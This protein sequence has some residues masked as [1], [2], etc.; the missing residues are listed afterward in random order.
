[1]YIVVISAL[2]NS[3]P[4]K[5]NAGFLQRLITPL[6]SANTYKGFSQAVSLKECGN[7]VVSIMPFKY[8]LLLSTTEIII[9]ISECALSQ[10]LLLITSAPNTAVQMS[11]GLGTA[12]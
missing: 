5:K 12:Y 2:W 3:L 10:W 1:M 7:K 8:S 11:Y 9:R 4:E 6:Q